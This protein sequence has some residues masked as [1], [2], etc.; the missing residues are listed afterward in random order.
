MNNS[1]SHDCQVTALR[2]R[3]GIDLSYEHEGLTMLHYAAQRLQVQVV[4]YF[5]QPQL[6]PEQLDRTS[7]LNGNSALHFAAEVSYFTSV[8]DYLSSFFRVWDVN[9]WDVNPSI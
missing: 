9:P 1:Y 3:A 7:S 8:V 6:S 2:S 5:L 4:E